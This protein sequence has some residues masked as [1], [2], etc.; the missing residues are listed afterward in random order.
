MRIFWA[1]L[2]VVTLSFSLT[3][4]VFAEDD[5][6]VV[7]SHD[8]TVIQA[9]FFEISSLDGKTYRLSDYADSIPLIV[10]FT[11][12]CGGCQ[13]NIPHLDSVYKAQIK[14]RAELL[15]VSLLGKDRKTV[16]EISEKL[17]FDFPIL[18]DPEGKTCEE[19]IGEYVEASCPVTNMF[20]I[21]QQGIVKYETHYPGNSETEAISALKALIDLETKGSSA[22]KEAGQ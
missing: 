2:F 21:D 5:I 18:F 1:I 4:T 13:A 14:P 3:E 6:D 16:K 17:K 9:P 10:W 12:L 22:G 15:A 19:Y 8:S 7:V 11:N 20:V